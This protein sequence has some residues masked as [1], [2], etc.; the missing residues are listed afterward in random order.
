M[1]LSLVKE[2]FSDIG[3]VELLLRISVKDC[4]NGEDD[5]SGGA[6]SVM[7]LA[8]LEISVILKTF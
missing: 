5:T 4:F 1:R 8:V 7:E 3:I 6:S 2:V